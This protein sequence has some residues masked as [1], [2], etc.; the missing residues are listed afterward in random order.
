MTKDTE[1]TEVLNAF[2]LVFTGKTGTEQSQ[3]FEMSGK[4]WSK[5]DLALVEEDQ[6]REHLNK[7][8]KHKSIG[9]DGMHQQ[10]LR[11]L[12]NVIAR[13]HSVILERSEQSGGSLEEV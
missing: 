8:D 9:P 5:E 3:A 13:P 11:E 4:V 2:A 12:A 6:I 1:K 7:L 10:V